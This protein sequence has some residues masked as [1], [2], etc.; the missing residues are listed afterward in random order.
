MSDRTYNRRTHTSD[1]HPTTGEPILI[2]FRSRSG[3]KPMDPTRPVEFLFSAEEARHDRL[4]IT[5]SATADTNPDRDIGDVVGVLN[6]QGTPDR[7][8]RVENGR[9]PRFSPVSILKDR[10][11]DLWLV[12]GQGDLTTNGAGRWVLKMSLSLNPQRYLAHQPS[13]E[14]DT[15]RARPPEVAL[16]VNEDVREEHA[17]FALDGNDTVILRTDH[18]GGTAFDNREQ[19]WR[20]ILGIY[21]DQVRN[22][23]AFELERC[24]FHNVV[25]RWEAVSQAE[26]AWEFTHADAVSWVGDLCRSVFATAPSVSWRRG[27]AIEAGRERNADWFIVS[28]AKHIKLRVYAK[29][30]SRIRVEIIY[31]D[32]ISQEANNRGRDPLATATILTTLMALS[33]RAAVRVLLAWNGFLRNTPGRAPAT[34][35]IL[36]FLARLDA[37]VPPDQRQAVLSILV[38]SGGITETPDD[39]G[40][41]KALC[42]ALQS[43]GLIVRCAIVSKRAPYRYVLAPQFAAAFDAIFRRD[44]RPVALVPASTE[45][46]AVAPM[47]PAAP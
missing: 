32:H 37:A 27:I 39:G 28:L 34:G 40:V 4:T 6:D 33:Q 46:T 8:F 13:A 18:A 7:L 16:R 19:Q 11:R 23:I 21:L 25:V 26:I 22:L 38:N 1:V 35:D 41:P 5:I 47:P 31:N 20:T 12:S 45:V 2:R 29:A 10:Q 14:P 3:F 15:L 9:Q 36:D 30:V 43:Q 44:A 24:Q 17:L 42:T